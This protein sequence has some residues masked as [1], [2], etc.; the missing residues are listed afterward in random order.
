MVCLL[1]FTDSK[2]NAISVLPMVFLCIAC[3]LRYLMLSATQLHH[4]QQPECCA[5]PPLARCTYTYASL[6]TE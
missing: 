1:L 4:D 3:Y 2:R 5:T 6:G